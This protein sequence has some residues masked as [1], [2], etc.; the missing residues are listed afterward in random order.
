MKDTYIQSIHVN[1][2]FHLQDFDIRIGDEDQAKKH[3]IITGPNGTGKTLLLNAIADSLENISKDKTLRFMTCRQGLQY[4]EQE[5]Q[6][7]ISQKDSRKIEKNKRMFEMRQAEID[8]LFGKVELEINNVE[9]LPNAFTERRFVIAYYGDQRRS[10]FKEVR[11]PEKPDLDYKDI[12]TN[13]VGEFI[14]FLVDLKVQR[15][16]AEGENA[17]EYAQEIE[18]WFSNFEGILRRLFCDD[19]LSLEFDFKTYSFFI[20]SQGKLFRFTELS[21]GYSAALDIV[22]DLILKMQER[23]RLTLSFNTP[24]IILIDEIETHLHLKMQKEI[25]H[26]ITTLFPNIQLIITTHSPFVLNSLPDAVAYDLEHREP[27]T[28]LTN[29]SYDALAEGYFEVDMESGRLFTAIEKI[30]QLA[31]KEKLTAIERNDLENLIHDFDNIPDA[32]A[33]TIKARYYAAIVKMDSSK[34]NDR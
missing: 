20:H 16:L 7:A 23:D 33:P 13:K 18:R 27:I 34:L 3:L 22:T 11:N 2:L 8:K 21:A 32:V 15:A 31:D 19:K 12:K 9:R 6:M 28:D 24:G 14:K 5:L 29:Y 1:K 30:E 25:L 4:Y 17:M 26:F 10:E